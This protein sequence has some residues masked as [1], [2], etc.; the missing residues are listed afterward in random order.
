MSLTHKQLSSAPQTMRDRV[1]ELVA[2]RSAATSVP[3][4]SADE[5]ARVRDTVSTDTWVQMVCADLGIALASVDA[6]AQALDT[7]A[8]WLLGGDDSLR[9]RPNLEAELVAGMRRHDV[10]EAD[11]C[12]ALGLDRD[13]LERLVASPHLADPRLVADFRR[14]LGPRA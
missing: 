14:V 7:T 3:G 8:E 10:D 5:I 13:G 12:E 4:M 11:V 9:A 2:E 1:A 6:L